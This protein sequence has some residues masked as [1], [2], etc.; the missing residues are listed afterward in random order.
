MSL[1]EQPT[2]MMK[3]YIAI[4]EQHKDCLL[5]F[6][7]GDFYELFFNDAVQAAGILGIALTKR[8]DTPMCGIPYHALENYLPKLTD[9]NLKIAICEQLESPEEA[10]RR[11]GHKAVVKRD[12]VR[13][14]TPGTIIEESLLDEKNPN[15]LASIVREKNNF[16]ICFIDLSTR[17]IYVTGTDQINLPSELAKISPKEILLSEK[18]QL[19]SEIVYI[20]SEYRSKIFYQVDSN[21]DYAK[22]NKRICDLYKIAS[23]EILGA[24]S[25]AQI[26]AVGSILE[27]LSITQKANIPDLPFPRIIDQSEYMQ[28]DAG[29]RRNLEI[30]KTL[31][32]NYKNSLLSIIDECVTKAGSRL[33]YEYI[34]NPLANSIKINHRLDITE[35]FYRNIDLVNKIRSV[36]KNISDIDRAL[37]RI[38]M[39]RAFPR[40]LLAIKYAISYALSIKELLFLERADENIYQNLICDEE[41]FAVIDSAIFEDAPVNCLNGGVIKPSYHPKIAELSELIHQSSQLVEKLQSS[42]RSE[43]GIDNL[44]ISHNNIFGFFIEVSAKA[45]PKMVGEKFIHKQTLAN[46]VRYVT[47]ELKE[48]ESKIVN[49]NAF[50]VA[51]EQEIFANICSQIMQKSHEISLMSKNLSEIDVFSSFARLSRERSYIRPIISNSTEFEIK[52]GRHPIV[53]I[54]LKASGNSF[55]PNDC[56]LSEI[57]EMHNENSSIIYLITGP[58][59]AGKST[60]LRQNALITIIAQIGCFVPAKFARIGVVDKLFSRIGAADDLSKGQST[61]MVE[62]IETATILLQSTKRSLIIL[63]EVG[64]GTSTYDGVSIA[65]SVLEYMHN[66]IGARA[67]FATHYHELVELENS[68]PNLKNYTIKISENNGKVIFMHKIVPGAADKS[69][70]IHVAEL[71]GLPKIVTRRAKQILQKLEKNYGDFNL[72][73]HNLSLFDY[74]QTKVD[75]QEDLVMLK[76]KLDALNPDALSPKEALEALYKLK[77]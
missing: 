4:K 52:D 50:L 63:D 75:L 1:V 56:N 31:N 43:T 61:F 54:S 29:T 36:L 3:Q 46:S 6:R 23:T 72:L 47:T 40:D 67:L 34:S 69:Y 5:L 8:G 70:G 71:A 60:F 21:F 39:K 59:M 24:L 62:M 45:S 17:A 41:I 14:I 58:N 20:F 13:I 32:G 68:L 77:E 18:M 38:A 12:V 64:R 44:K 74:V 11:H 53:E 19:D 49:A 33:L 37:S 42:Y 76:E 7:M 16:G 9:E 73:D 26:S 10:K 48:L 15:Y 25:K 2:P 65:W 27:Y 66:Q 57:S 22:C 35:Y 51:L 28:I 55:V 30:A